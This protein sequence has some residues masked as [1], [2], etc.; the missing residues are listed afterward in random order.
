MFQYPGSKRQSEM[1]TVC[2][3]IMDVRVFL[4]CSSLK[5]NGVKF[6]LSKVP[7]LVPQ[8]SGN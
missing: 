2:K 3:T 5:L 8:L 6:V 4:C 7:D 1:F